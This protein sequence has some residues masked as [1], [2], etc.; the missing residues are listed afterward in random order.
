MNRTERRNKEKAEKKN[1]NKTIEAMKWIN[2]LS[3]ERME[4][5]K[6]MLNTETEKEQRHIIGAIERCYTAGL[7][8]ILGDDITID[9]IEKVMEKCSEFLVEDAKTIAIQKNK[10]GGNYEMAVKKING[11]AGEV[12]N[13]IE[14]L[15]GEG[16]K[17]KELADKI[18]YEYPTLTKAMITNSIKRVKENL[19]KYTKEIE[20]VKDVI[21][22]EEGEKQLLDILENHARKEVDERVAEVEVIP[23]S[24]EIIEEVAAEVEEEFEILKEVRVVDF[25]GKYGTYKAENKCLTVDGVLCFGD[26]MQVRE[27]CSDEVEKMNLIID[28]LKAKQNEIIRGLKYLK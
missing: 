19:K 12:G 13:R 6:N 1:N 24:K 25:K 5:I 8:E 9:Q 23:G 7:I 27:W 20:I 2:S 18:S 15:L 4:M 16:L 10:C 28:N 3:P 11:L 17:N 14:D 26:E 22:E 21:S